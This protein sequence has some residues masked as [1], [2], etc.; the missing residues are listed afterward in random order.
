[1]SRCHDVIRWQRGDVYDGKM[2]ERKEIQG[3]GETVAQR[4]RDTL[5]ATSPFLSHFSL[6]LL[7]EINTCILV[8]Y[9][10]KVLQFNRKL[11]T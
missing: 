7:L 9:T 4:E 2:R 8:S 5:L 3:G 1:M 6:Y 10:F 11:M